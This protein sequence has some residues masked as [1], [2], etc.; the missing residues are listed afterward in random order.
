MT[1]D[2]IFEIY[3]WGCLA[4]C[5]GLVI[6]FVF[7]PWFVKNPDPKFGYMLSTTSGF[8]LVVFYIFFVAVP[9]VNMLTA[10]AYFWI[11]VSSGLSKR[12]KHRLLTQYA[13]FL[14][15]DR[16]LLTTPCPACLTEGI[17][18]VEDVGG[19][20]VLE[21]VK[22][23]CMNPECNHTVTSAQDTCCARDWSLEYVKLHGT[24]F[25]ALQAG[26]D[27]YLTHHDFRWKPNVTNS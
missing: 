9:F 10:A 25:D 12:F 21:S 15:V 5:V 1:K 11:W 20:N 18:F 13:M 8:Q 16:K 22:M 27:G 24:W 19:A 26:R 4:A 23:T 6:Y 17:P 2:L 3:L 7:E 14:N